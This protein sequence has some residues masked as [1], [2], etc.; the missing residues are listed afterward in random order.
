VKVLLE[1]GPFDVAPQ[2]LVDGFWRSVIEAGKEWGLQVEV[3]RTP[4]L[5]EA[6]QRFNAMVIERDR[7]AK[8]AGG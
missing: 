2:P 6:V 3:V 5:H 1:A 7:L 8:E 4:S